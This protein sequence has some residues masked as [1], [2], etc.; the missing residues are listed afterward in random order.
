M[1]KTM[2]G[3]PKMLKINDAVHTELSDV[4]YD[5]YLELEDAIWNQKH[6]R[7]D[8]ELNRITVTQFYHSLLATPIDRVGPCGPYFDTCRLLC[9]KLKEGCPLNKNGGK[10]RA[11]GH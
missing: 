6:E 11:W 5:P 7:I 2:P 4:D 1:P 8:I 9:G 3:Y 10:F